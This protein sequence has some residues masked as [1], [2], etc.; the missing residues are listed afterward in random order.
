MW[1]CTCRQF[2]SS[3][4]R[5]QFAMGVIMRQMHFP[6]GNSYEANTILKCIC[7]VIAKFN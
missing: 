3:W 6:G 7:T 1:D 4:R 5:V 2:I